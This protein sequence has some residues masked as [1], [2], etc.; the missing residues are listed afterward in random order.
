MLTKIIL[1]MIL[2][3]AMAGIFKVLIKLFYKVALPYKQVLIITLS[4]FIGSYLVA[5][6]GTY[7]LI[8]L[9]QANQIY[10]MPIFGLLLCLV[11]LMVIFL[12][13]I[14]I[15]RLQTTNIE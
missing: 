15:H 12:K 1:L 6:M 11:T 8:A 10:I 4:S 2:A 9:G 13:A 7:G 5:I 14:K 3:I